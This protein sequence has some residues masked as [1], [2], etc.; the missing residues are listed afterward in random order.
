MLFKRI[1]GAEGSVD[2]PALGA[3]VGTMGSWILTPRE[4]P[5]SDASTYDLRVVFSYVNPW[6]FNNTTYQKR[7]TIRLSKKQQ[8]RLDIVP[9]ARTVLDGMSLL[10]EGVTLNV[11]QDTRTGVRHS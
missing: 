8:F 2:I 6:L 4:D 1:S 9:S 11:L 10:I 3:V 5:G 7:I